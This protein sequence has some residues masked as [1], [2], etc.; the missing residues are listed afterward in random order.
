MD[1]EKQ[2]SELQQI[3][4]LLVEMLKLQEFILH[5]LEKLEEA[6]LKRGS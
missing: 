4:D 6:I 5:R 2:S 1:Q 3:K